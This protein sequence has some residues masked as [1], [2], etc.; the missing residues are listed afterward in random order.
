MGQ[1]FEIRRV[2]KLGM[3]F[4]PLF[5]NLEYIYFQL[6][7]NCYKHA[8]KWIWIYMP[9]PWFSIASVSPKPTMDTFDFFS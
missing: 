7:S 4:I 5:Y 1:W 8:L 9:R 2:L 3:L 6:F